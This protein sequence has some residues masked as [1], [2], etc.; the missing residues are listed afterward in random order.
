MKLIQT[1]G[2]LFR[3]AP[4]NV[5]VTGQDGR[6][7]VFLLGTTSADDSAAHRLM[8]LIGHGSYDIYHAAMRRRGLVRQS[9]TTQDGQQ[10]LVSTNVII[11]SGSYI[12]GA[13][14]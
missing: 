13:Q 3:R 5:V 11:D 2:N 12:A 14:R 10:V 8:K 1:L 4:L 7:D 9:Y 6:A